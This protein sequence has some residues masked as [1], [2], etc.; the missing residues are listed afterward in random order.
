MKW[1]VTPATNDAL[2][3]DMVQPFNEAFDT[4][5]TA[6]DIE[7]RYNLVVNYSDLSLPEDDKPKWTRN[8]EFLHLASKVLRSRDQKTETLIAEEVD[9][10]FQWK[11]EGH[12]TADI[13]GLLLRKFGTHH[14]TH[15]LDVRL[16]EIAVM[17][18]VR[19]KGVA[20]IQNWS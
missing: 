11:L 17:R 20:E 9:Q 2:W 8:S 1:I 3:S 18:N 7:E 12:A 4:S 10:A 5:C 14:P 13:A 16:V 19:L 15:V 6:G